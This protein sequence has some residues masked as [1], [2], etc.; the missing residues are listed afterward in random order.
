MSDK[1]VSTESAQ[2]LRLRQVLSII[3]VSRSHWW[4]GV[5]DG[6]FPKGIKLSERITCWRS[7]DIQAL[8][9]KLDQGAA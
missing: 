1:T 5:A 3:P 7:G 2:L 6:R 4:A 9:S 8:M